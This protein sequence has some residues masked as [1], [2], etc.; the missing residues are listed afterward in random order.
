MRAGLTVVPG[1]GRFSSALLLLAGA[2]LWVIAVG[3]PAKAAG[4]TTETPK[5]FGS[6]EI[7]SGN[8]S[9]FEKWTEVLGR[10]AKEEPN[11]L[12]KCAPT[13]FNPCN[14][15]RWRIFLYSLKDLPKRQ[16]LDSVNAYLNKWMYIID[17]VNWGK[18]D[19]WATP[20]Q[21]LVKNGDCEDYAI[22]KYVSLL[23]LG[24]DKSQLRI[25]VLNDLN[26]KVPHA[27][28]AVY[29]D[30]E[31]LILDNQIVQVV[32]ADRIKHYKPIYS[33]NEGSWWL[34]RS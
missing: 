30:G 5:L 19:Y 11:E 22:A 8:L 21:F 33:I 18:S 14:T 31:V 27:I 4:T 3:A 2:V 6:T 7:R 1:K 34:H 25:V 9:K 16:Q 15:A 28:L 32:P 17:Q 23:H 24:F 12:Q 29:L 10:Y 13:Q 26:L 20:G